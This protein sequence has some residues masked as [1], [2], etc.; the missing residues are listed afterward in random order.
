[1]EFAGAE[2]LQVCGRTNAKRIL[3]GDSGWQGHRTELEKVH[4]QSDLE[5]GRPGTG[6]LQDAELPAAARLNQEVAWLLLFV[7]RGLISARRLPVKPRNQKYIAKEGT[8]SEEG[9][10][11]PGGTR[12][13]RKAR[14]GILK[15]TYRKTSV[16]E[17]V[18]GRERKRERENM[19][20]LGRLY[21]QRSGRTNGTNEH[22][23][24]GG[25]DHQQER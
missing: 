18:R 1:M 23:T 6:V 20:E 21:T 22:A 16:R 4:L 2:Q 17:N 7:V 24:Y 19:R 3:Q 12:P 11:P 15:L 25:I 13:S 9:S 10:H 5:A 14:S 8:V